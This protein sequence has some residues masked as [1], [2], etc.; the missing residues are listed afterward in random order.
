MNQTEESTSTDFIRTII[1][2]DMESGKYDGRVH[3][4]FPPEPNGYLHIGH[5]KS[6][7]FNF[8][9]AK[10]YGGDTYLRFDDTNPCKENNEFIDHI[11]EIVG[12]LE[13][14]GLNGEILRRYPHQLSGGQLQRVGVARALSLNP[15]VLYADEPTS[16]LDVSVQAQVLNLLMEIRANLGLTLVMISHDLAVISR[17]CEQIVVMKDGRIV[18]AGP[19]TEILSGSHD[20][21]TVSLV[22]SARKVSLKA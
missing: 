13:R 2:E 15:D 9:V 3:T 21:Y 5:V 6:I 18:E 19:M 1:N 12:W 20:P 10:E 16:A 17:T 14:V 22:D 11:K 7:R 8:T 4:R